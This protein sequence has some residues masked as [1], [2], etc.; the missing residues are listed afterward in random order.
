MIDLALGQPVIWRD[1]LQSYISS[2]PLLMETTYSLDPSTH[3]ELQLH[4]R[5]LHAE[6]GQVPI[7]S[8]VLLASGIT[9]VLCALLFSIQ[10]A[11]PSK[12]I[13]VASEVLYYAF[14]PSIIAVLGDLITFVPSI[15]SNE[16]TLTA[17]TSSSTLKLT[18][19]DIV[20]QVCTSPSNPDGL[21][22][23]A[24]EYLVC[25]ETR[26]KISYVM[27]DASYAWP[28]YASADSIRQI[29]DYFS[30]IKTPCIA[31]YSLSKSVGL[32]GQRIGYP[33]FLKCAQEQNK[34]SLA[35][36]EYVMQNT[37]GNNQAG[38]AMS[39][40][41]LKS[42]SLSRVWPQIACILCDRHT[43]VTSLIQ[44]YARATSA[45]GIPYLFVEMRDESKDAVEFFA[46]RFGWNVMS[47]TL[48]GG[49]AHTARINLM[50][51]LTC[52]IANG[53]LYKK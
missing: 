45:K 16:K 28:C 31:L 15:A 10:K 12:R 8:N 4:L 24:H 25:N 5:K 38:I 14:L 13:I 41:V 21:M 43:Y 46:R 33:L 17:Y 30:N 19:K 50:Y 2:V 11:N 34:L 7:E 36:N 37:L 39:T 1:V 29:V 23:R 3:A 26:R 53:A 22:R 48:F 51:S 42:I 20:V 9:Q 35:F 6:G 49:S 27:W 40:S 52:D 44:K 32:A 47:G 18:K